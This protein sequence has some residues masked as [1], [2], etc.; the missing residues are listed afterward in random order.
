MLGL[1]ALLLLDVLLGVLGDLDFPELLQGEVVYRV[2]FVQLL[3][4]VLNERLQKQCLLN[5]VLVLVR[6]VYLFPGSTGIRSSISL[7]STASDH[8]T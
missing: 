3:V 7:V 2:R 4:P 6:E 1:V 5:L 8:A